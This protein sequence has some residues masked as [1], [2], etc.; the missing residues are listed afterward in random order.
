MKNRSSLLRRLATA[1]SAIG[2]GQSAF[3][4]L[5]PLVMERQRLDTFAIGA[6]T[7]VGA[8]AFLVGSPL[9]GRMG[10]RLGHARLLRLLGL[11]MLAGQAVFAILLI[12]GT[13]AA[14]GI[15]LLMLSRTVYGFA[16][17]GVMPTAQVW[18]SRSV[19]DDRRQAALGLLGAGVSM[20]RLAGAL[21]ATAAVLSPLLPP[22][23]FLFSPLLLWLAR[24]KGEAGGRTDGRA[25]DVGRGISPFDRRALPCL[26]MGLC[27]TLGF[28]QVQMM[29]GPMTQQRFGLGATQ[30]TT[31]TGL[32]LMLVAVV[33]VLVQGLL[34]ARLR[35]AERNSVI[36]GCLMVCVGM[37]ALAVTA[38]H[39]AS[40][41]SLVVAAAGIAL[42]TP[43][44]TAWL[45]KRLE[46]GEQGAAAGWLTSTHVLGQ[47]IG[48]LAGGFAFTLWPFAP[49][50]GC[51][52][53]A[54]AAAG[55]AAMIHKH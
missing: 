1:V 13:G 29:L 53:L 6:A 28:G 24:G 35:L 48:A 14:L 12:A 11:A 47:S 34:M 18:A 42:A 32:A 36:V 10:E 15:A 25:A 21:A 23:L 54:L 7:A 2:F 22:I 8:A 17:S 20:G 44:Y 49:L 30:A 43:G 33:M 51:A 5:V 9:W 46:P 38:S 50:A 3:V 26:A 27:L 4:S 39:V 19:A 55:L 31:L 45:M 41:A 16:A 52:A 37:T 40:A